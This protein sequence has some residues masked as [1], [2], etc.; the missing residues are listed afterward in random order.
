[1]GHRGLQLLVVAGNDDG[2]VDI[3]AHLNGLHD[4]VAK[5]IQ[6]LIGQSGEGEVNPDTSQNT[7]DE[8]NRQSRRL[9]SEQQHQ[10]NEQ[11]GQNGDYQIVLDKGGRQIAGAGGIAN[12]VVIAVVVFPHNVPHFGQECKGLVAFLRQV[13]VDHHPA[14]AI[15]F[16]LL[17][18]HI[19]LGENIVQRRF[20]HVIQRNIMGI[21]LVFQEH[22][23][24]EQGN[25]VLIQPLYEFSVLVVLNG[26]GGIE[27]LRYLVIHAHQLGKLSGV[28]AVRQG[29][30]V[31]SLDVG[32]A[33]GALDLR[34]GIQFLQ[35]FR[36][37]VIV[38]AGNHQR[39][40]VGRAEGMLDFKVGRLT[41]VHIRGLDVVIAVNKGAAVGQDECPDQK[42]GKQRRHNAPGL[43]RKLADRRDVWQ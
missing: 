14:V 35:N 21:Q 20:V 3:R 23:H 1:M 28:Q 11:G 31:H 26:V 17:L 6:R 42:N 41:F 25:V 29:V 9:E 39:D 16:Q 30:A 43:H 36:F 24:I 37:R 15:A 34:A 4:E 40:H 19:Q 10:N 38:A 7:G 5:E 2:V 22:Q 33:H 27:K 32:K 18:S 12:H 13:Q 8:Q